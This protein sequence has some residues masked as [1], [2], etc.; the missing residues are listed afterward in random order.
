MYFVLRGKVNVARQSLHESF[1][2]WPTGRVRQTARNVFINQGVLLAEMFRLLGKPRRNPLDDIKYDREQLAIFDEVMKQKKGALVL[3]AHIN[4]YEFL[5][6]WA[7]RLFPM[8]IAAKPIK[9]LALGEFIKKMRK[10]AGINEL[11]HHGSY[12]GL[13]RAAKSGSVIGFIMDQNMKKNQGV[14]VTF[15]GKPASTTAGLAML[16]AHAQVPVVPVFILRDGDHY[17]IKLFPAIPPPIDRN[18]E[19]LQDATQKYS[20]VIEQVIREQ[21]E[22]W[23]WLHRRWKTKPQPGDRITLPDGSV[24]YA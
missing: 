10:D 24:R 12:R 4:N 22:S 14:F 7:A 17:R 19:T 3:T 23:I 13:L 20:N 18:I 21:P 2:D 15:F 1:P 9:P 6:A 5:Q 8:C 16:S 11:P